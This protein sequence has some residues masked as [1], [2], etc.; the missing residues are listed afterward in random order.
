QLLA[1]AHGPAARAKAGGID[2]APRVV[3]QHVHDGIDFVAANVE[4][5]DPVRFQ[6]PLVDLPVAR[7][8]KLVGGGVGHTV[9]VR[10]GAPVPSNGGDLEANPGDVRVVGRPVEDGDDF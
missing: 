8:E 1:R 2:D 3:R 7:S 10:G 5:G 4:A 9:A 6:V